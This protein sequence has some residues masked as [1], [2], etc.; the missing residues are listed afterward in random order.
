MACDPT[1]S[2]PFGTALFNTT[3]LGEMEGAYGMNDAEWTDQLGGE[4]KAGVV[5]TLEVPAAG[6]GSGGGGDAGEGAADERGS[7]VR[8]AASL[9]S[10]GWTKVGVRFGSGLGGS[11]PLTHNMICGELSWVGMGLGE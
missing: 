11:L 9:D 3:A 4:V 8:M 7:L 2:V 1:T 10:L 6:G 5:W